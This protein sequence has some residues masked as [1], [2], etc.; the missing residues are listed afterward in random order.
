MK[1]YE[2]VARIRDE[3]PQKKNLNKTNQTKMFKKIL[4]L[5]A[6]FSA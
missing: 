3:Y 6:V 4:L 1:N 2:K 5:L